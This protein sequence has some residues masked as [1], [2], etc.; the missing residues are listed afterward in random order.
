[1][2]SNLPP[3]PQRT[4]FNFSRFLAS[5]LCRVVTW[6]VIVSLLL[7]DWPVFLELPESSAAAVL[8]GPE[9]FVRGTGKPQTVVRTFTGT[10]PPGRATLCIANG[11]QT[12]SMGA[13]QVPS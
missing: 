9:D 8:F 10:N 1:M 6:V 13:S 3:D 4:G 12:T 11:G 2:A 7:A 5:S